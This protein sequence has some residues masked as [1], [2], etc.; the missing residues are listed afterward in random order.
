MRHDPDVTGT[1]TM[2]TILFSGALLFL[3]FANTL[4]ADR[5]AQSVRPDVQDQR[6]T[7]F[8]PATSQPVTPPE[9]PPV[10]TGCADTPMMDV[11]GAIDPAVQARL[12]AANQAL[13]MALNEYGIGGVGSDLRID[14]QLQQNSV[15]LARMTV[16]SCAENPCD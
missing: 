7:T 8:D 15:L 11:P 14:Q 12:E 6:I 4:S 10:D 5:P 9:T 3:F 16:R 1:S 13:L 2:K